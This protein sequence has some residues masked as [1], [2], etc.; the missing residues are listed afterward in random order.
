M[1]DFEE[2]ELQPDPERVIVGLRDT[3]Y[4]FNTAVADIVDNSIA[5][6]ATKVVLELYADFG[7]NIRLMIAD[8]G[9]GM[10]RQGLIN[11]MRY[12]SKAR[13]NPASLGKYGLGL[14]TA[15]TAFCK[16]L[17]VISRPDG[18]TPALMA[19]WDLYH[20]AKVNK[21]SLLVSDKCDEESLESLEIVAAG[22]SG[23]V[24]LWE[25]VDRLIKDYSKPSG[26][27]A[28]KA[29][30]AK[31]D[32]LRQHL[33][34]IYQRFLD[35]ND[36][37]AQ[38]VSIELNGVPVIAWD[39]FQRGLSELVAEE[40]L[41]V[42]MDSGKEASFVVRAFILPR[43]EEFPDDELAK[44]AML[45]NERQGIYIYRENRLIHDADWL[46]LYQKEPH[47]TQLRV[48]FSF[49][50]RLDD[51]FHL[52]IK[53]SQ[54]ILNE[55][56][57]SWLQESFLP[58]P[59]REANRRSREGQQKSIS[60]KGSGA[61]DT[62]NNNIRNREAVAGG[63]KVGVVDTVAGTAEID[64]KYGKTR[65]KLTIAAAK[66]PGEVFVQPV[67][68]INNGLL[69]QPA[70]IEQHKAVQV[71]TSHPYYHKVYV[72]NL[73]RSVTMQGLD[74]LMWALSVAELSTVQ[75]GTAA[76][77]QDMR[78]EISRILEKLVETL[79]DPNGGEDE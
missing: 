64:N 13:P 62:S 19:T 21:W 58:A 79:P 7:G 37:R 56:L 23:T 66:R 10:D 71:N 65:L 36:K 41:Q 55:D 77:F 28:Q 40:T 53:K 42:E 52:D 78:Y 1:N 24:V 11:A 49:D 30:K 18:K 38:D 9:D 76:M 5:A 16:R 72:P 70:I 51:A 69:F 68:G 59:R 20:V 44:K 57:A 26:K 31:E 60:K 8:N 43:R 47:I 29:L 45:T 67:E 73:N 4:E 48:E 50:H 54:I 46:G 12:G 15:S 17:S 33:A 35:P 75:D 2:I 74:S 6:N 32:A 3:G 14:K 27:P 22:H 39:P 25:E 63:P 34:M 61:H